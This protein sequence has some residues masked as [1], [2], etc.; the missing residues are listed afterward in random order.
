MPEVRLELTIP[1]SIWIGQ[2]TRQFSDSTFRVLCVQ[3]NGD[4]GV[5]LAE[6]TSDSLTD[7]LSEMTAFDE[8][9]EM[10]V[11]NE[12]VDSSLVQYDTSA[13]FL[14]HPAHN[15]G[16]PLATPFELSDGV[17]NWELTA[18][19]GRLSK[20][21]TQLEDF[22]IS[23]TID[24][25]QHD[26]DQEQLLTDAQRETVE[27]AIEMGYYDTPRE[28]SLTEVAEAVDRAKSTVSETIHRAE[29][30]VMKQFVE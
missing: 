25:L 4:G 2:L 22:G 26:V 7:V 18:S 8:V 5:A 1:E 28:C 16:V 23:F 30:K 24:S 10:H 21:A 29:G 12:H 27:C 17:A 14:L 15:S 19:S 11:L 6:I 3:P 9:T 20:L 13:P